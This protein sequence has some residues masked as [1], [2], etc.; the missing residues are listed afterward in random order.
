MLKMKQL[1]ECLEIDTILSN[2]YTISV[3]DKNTHDC[4]GYPVYNEYIN[5]N[6]YNLWKRCI[7]RKLAKQH[8]IKEQAVESIL[9]FAGYWVSNPNTISA[10]Y[11]S[12]EKYIREIQEYKLSLMRQLKD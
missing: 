9:A 11:N 12:P 6:L 3:E 10:K 8:E 4:D 1:E 2:K 7:C 5:P